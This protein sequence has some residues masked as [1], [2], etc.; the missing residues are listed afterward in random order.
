MK[1]GLISDTHISTASWGMLPEVVRAFQ[2]VDLILH[3]G[4]IYTSVA[5]DWLE[6]IAPVAAALGN[7]DFR[8]RD[9]PR[10]KNS[11][12]L[13]L[14]GL[15][16]GVIHEMDYPDTPWRPLEKT[17]QRHFGGPVDVLVYGD[18]HRSVVYV[19]KGMLVVNPGSA[20]VSDDFFGLGTVG[21]LEI[22]GGRASVTILRLG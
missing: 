20:T 13:I 16:V 11:Q 6:E 4:D 10:V 17:T 7:G 1:I 12:L 2:G 3:A 19:W 5:L 15:R 18:T 14:D 21:I 8:V 9:D 22:S